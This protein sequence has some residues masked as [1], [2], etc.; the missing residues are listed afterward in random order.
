[1]WVF[2]FLLSRKKINNCLLYVYKTENSF[3]LF[4]SSKIFHFGKLRKKKSLFH[5]KLVG[6]IFNG[7]VSVA[8]HT[9]HTNFFRFFFMHKKYIFCII[10]S[11]IYRNTFFI[12]FLYNLTWCAFYWFTWEFFLFSW[13]TNFHTF[14]ISIQ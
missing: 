7:I 3:V 1:M 5:L 14:F 12:L 11:K 9:I 4:L 8:L 13:K 10:Q 6:K 2:L